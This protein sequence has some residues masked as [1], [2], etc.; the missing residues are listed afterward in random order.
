MTS[1]CINRLASQGSTLRPLT[2]PYPKLTTLV[3][4]C[5]PI[6]GIWRGA[7]NSVHTDF[8]SIDQNWT[9]ELGTIREIN[10]ELRL[11]NLN[12]PRGNPL[13]NPGIVVD[14]A[15]GVK[16]QLEHDLPSERWV[17][18]KWQGEAGKVLCWKD[19]GHELRM[20]ELRRN[21][22]K[23]MGRENQVR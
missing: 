16:H 9:A 3:I 8:C 17:T 13:F 2:P 7:F 18:Y 14:K 22:Q 21:I 5:E 23:C 4:I 1:R 20:C 12:P 10:F 11:S 6:F 19:E 15:L